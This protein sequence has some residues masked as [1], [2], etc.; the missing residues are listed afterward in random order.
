MRPY[1]VEIRSFDDVK[2]L[3]SSVRSVPGRTEGREHYHEER[4]YLGLYLLALGTYELLAYPFQIAQAKQQHESPDFMLKW[5]SGQATG[6]EVTRATEESFQENVMTAAERMYSRRKAGAAVSGETTEPMSVLLS[7]D[8]WI[9]D[10]A[11]VE[12]CS[13]VQKAI[14][15]KLEKLPSFKPASRHD[16]VIYDDTPLPAVNRRKVVA[17]LN[18][19]VDSLKANRPELG[20]ISIIISLDVVFDVGSSVR[21]LP[22]VKWAATELGAPDESSDLSE[23]IEYAG[24]H[25]VKRALRKPVRTQGPVYFM[26]SHGRLVKQMADGRRFKVRVKEDGEEEEVEVVSKRPPRA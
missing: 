20:T 12:W 6:F 8:G 23:R 5:S 1:L 24:W 19:W 9:G 4:Y 16:L 26:D 25:A 21:I 2:R 22:Y 7:E 3:W 10:K 17:A 13:F 18:P 14:E 15:K 11:E